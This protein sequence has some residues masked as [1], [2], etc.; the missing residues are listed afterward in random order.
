MTTFVLIPGAGGQ[1]AY[2]ALLVPELRRRGHEGVA[3]DIAEDDPALGLPEY[4][5][6]VEEAI[7]DRRDVVLVAQSLAGFTAPMVAKPVSMIVLL[8]AMIPVPG[9][10]PG[11]W[12]ESSG[13]GHARQAADEAA[14]RSGEFDPETH[15]LHD[16]SAEAMAALVAAGPP[17]QPA[18]TAFGQPCAFERW[19]DV[20]I[21]VLISSG[22]RFFPAEF[23]RR[24]AKDR[25]GIDADVIDG[26]HLVALA[27]PTGLADQLDAY[28]RLVAG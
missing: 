6:I 19:P 20:P 28:A 15:F 4:A 9:E 23:Q 13:A 22:D 17:R 11:Q 14:G 5:Q 2:W 12:F 8:N 27:N 16:L 7:G 26:G 25:L 18:D 1:A 21:R 10:T 3:V 24:L